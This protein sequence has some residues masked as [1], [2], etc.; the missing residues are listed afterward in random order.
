MDTRTA[1][2]STVGEILREEFLIPLKITQNQLAKQMGVT[3]KVIN[4]IVN[5]HRRISVEEAVRLSLLLGM[6]SNF[7][8][9]VQTA[10][11]CWQAR[12]LT[13][14]IEVSPFQ[15]N[16]CLRAISTPGKRPTSVRKVR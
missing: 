10:H 12:Q 11:D 5:N 4:Q 16:L 15:P 1:E 6:D 8:I 7:W 14:T 13:K 2:P 3:R 9:N